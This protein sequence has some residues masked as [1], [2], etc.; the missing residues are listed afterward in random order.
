MSDTV[1]TKTAK[2]LEQVQEPS[3]EEIVQYRLKHNTDFYN[4]R[5]EL[6]NLA[7]GGLPPNGFASWGDYWK[8]Y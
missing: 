1:T 5:E 3:H 7:H 4:A 6:R 8:S 2:E